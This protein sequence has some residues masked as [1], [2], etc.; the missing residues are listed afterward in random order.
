MEKANW[1]T[2]FDIYGLLN[3]WRPRQMA[4]HE[5]ALGRPKAL[6]YPYAGANRI[7]FKGSSRLCY[8]R[9]SPPLRR[10]HLINQ[11]KLCL[12]TKVNKKATK[13]LF[14]GKRRIA[15]DLTDY[16]ALT[17]IDRT[18]YRTK[19]SRGPRKTES[20]QNYTFRKTRRPVAPIPKSDRRTASEYSAALPMRPLRPASRM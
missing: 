11:A 12:P 2:I 20:R 15:V 13:P 5:P 7:R 14:S 9:P 3:V 17:L 16:A 1:L 4:T 6:S 18:R 8:L 19:H 10:P